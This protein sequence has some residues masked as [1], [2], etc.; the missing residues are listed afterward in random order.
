M[1][2][3]NNNK[4]EDEIKE[5]ND[6]ISTL[7]LAI[8]ELNIE[9]KEKARHSKK[10]IR[11]LNEK[12]KTKTQ[13]L[14][15]LNEN[16]ERVSSADVQTGAYNRRYFYDI[17]ENI[18][19]ISKREKKS[20]TL[21]IIYIDKYKN[22]IETYGEEKSNN[23]LQTFVHTITKNIR[24]SDVFVRFDE[25]E[26]VLLFP[27]TCLDQALVIS[28]KLRKSVE[29]S[30]S[31]DHLKFTISIGISEYII[32]NDNINIT[33]KRISDLFQSEHSN[34]TNKVISI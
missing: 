27:N 7:Q 20:I 24:E 26:F 14:K 30:V 22:I 12:L 34:A 28:E 23:I 5:K 2:F 25:E 29:N 3:G 21:A 13:K 9:S 4:L 17:A 16:L 1:F 33:L 15:I 32:S 18:I 10:E 11:V 8:K 6:Q 19:S 31:H